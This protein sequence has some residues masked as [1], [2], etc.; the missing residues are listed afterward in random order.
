M[1]KRPLALVCLLLTLFLYFATVMR[2]MP[3]Q[4][5]SE[6]EGHTTRITGRVYKKEYIKQADNAV[7]VLYLEGL[8]SQSPPGE[9]AICY[10]NVGEEEPYMGSEIKLEGKLK[11]FERASNPGQFDSYSYY[12]VS[13]VSYR[14]NQ[15]HILE[16]TIEYSKW[17][18]TLYQFRKSLVQKLDEN[19]P[20]QES[21]LMQTMLLGEKSELDKELKALYQRNGIAHILAISGLHVSMLGIGLFKLLRKAGVPLKVSAGMSGMVL[22]LYGVMTGFSVSSKRA[23]FMFVLHM[24]AVL[25]KRTYDMLTALA[26]AAVVILIGQPYYIGQSGFVFSFGCVLGIGLVLPALTET[27]Q[28]L[29]PGVKGL[30]SAFAMATVSLPIYLWFFYQFPIY[31]IFLNLLVIPLMSYLM[32]AGLILL[33]FSV[34]FVPF[35]LPCALLIEGTFQIFE[36]AC[37]LCDSLPGHLLN[38]GK[39]RVWQMLLYLGALLLVVVLKK[40][41]KLVVRW[42]ITGAAVL[43][44]LFPE[45]GEMKLTFLDVGQGDGIYIESARGSRFLVDGGST[46]VSGVGEYRLIPFLKYQGVS[47]LDAVFITHPDED[48]CNGIRELLEKG[49]DHGIY[50]RCIVLPDI[51]IQA[52]DEAYVELEKAALAENIPVQYISSGQVVEADG[53]SL[54]CLH[55]ESRSSI[56][57]ANEYS[58]V[59]K[60]TYGEFSALLTGDLEGAGEKRLLTLMGESGD[61]GVTVL[62]V[63]H[64]G[65]G[66]STSKEFL[67][68]LSP[69]YT[70]IS[71]GKNNSYGHPH[72]ELIE[73]LD[74]CG[75]QT[76]ITYETGAITFCTDGKRVKVQFYA[77]ELYIP[78]I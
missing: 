37:S 56:Q 52:R 76:L 17:R 26:V 50:V 66:N 36:K 32:A 24:F 38:I 64:H 9:K 18:E 75:T 46:S 22:V 31:S 11:A 15:A 1:V 57:D 28:K 45:R 33:F 10:L 14:L 68:C 8:S 73:R 6:Y 30:L 58:M 3:Y 29:L 51:A 13:G 41:S 34:I 27:K 47:T 74:N 70:V 62:K 77:S 49:K 48:H 4:D 21:A 60:L 43:V 40:K 12:Q 19:L 7:L 35:I 55:P 72:A 78:L 59:L 20:E 25:M 71:C 54:V 44:F 2:P 42:V 16:K 61:S 39:P 53:L 65:S 69:Y 5:Y 67:E 23:V 63:A